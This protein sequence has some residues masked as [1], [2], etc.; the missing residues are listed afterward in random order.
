MKL[1][2]R[3]DDRKGGSVRMDERLVCL[4]CSLTINQMEVRS[5]FSVKD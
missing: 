4:L 3:K 5:Q 2:E 1:R